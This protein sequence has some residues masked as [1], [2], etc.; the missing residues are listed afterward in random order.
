MKDRNRILRYYKKKMYRGRSVIARAFDFFAL[1]LVFAASCY[2]WF[3]YMVHNKVLSI[4]LTVIALLMFCV[5]A[6]L[7]SSIRLDKFIAKEHRRLQHDCLSEQMILM[8]RSEFYSLAKRCAPLLDGM[9]IVQN[10]LTMDM[11]PCLLYTVQQVTPVDSNVLLKAYQ[12]ARRRFLSKI[13]LFSSSEITAD[14][15]AFSKRLNEVKFRLVEPKVIFEYAEKLG[16]FA[17]TGQMEE[18]ILKEQETAKQKLRTAQA[19]PFSAGRAGRYLIAAAALFALSF[20][21][22]YTLYYRMIAGACAGFAGI[23]FWLNHPSDVIETEVQ[24]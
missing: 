6:Q 13:L 3:L 11:Q 19:L 9:K 22:E 1:R 15:K 21:T 14:A 8:P 18:K 7:I 20:A 24:G 10:E 2:L 17:D 5:A 12:A 16:L 4:I 23:S